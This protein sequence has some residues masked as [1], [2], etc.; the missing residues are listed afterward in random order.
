MHT[1]LIVIM[2]FQMSTD[3]HRCYLFL[4]KHMEIERERERDKDVHV[5]TH[6]SM[7]HP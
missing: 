5:I 6:N 3:V 4:E 1:L 7:W 2:Y